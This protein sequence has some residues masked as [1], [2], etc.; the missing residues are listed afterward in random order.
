MYTLYTLHFSFTLPG[1]A[2]IRGLFMELYQCTLYTVHTLFTVNCTHTVHSVHCSHTL[3]GPA[4]LRGLVVE[5]D[6]CTLYTVHVVQ[7]TLCTWYT[8]HTVHTLYLAPLRSVASSWN[9]TTRFSFGLSDVSSLNQI[10]SN[11][12]CILKNVP[13]AYTCV[14]WDR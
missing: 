7:N 11:T 9:L 5:L 4:A 12:M 6:Q 8:L 1:P 3:P 14:L 13:S 10:Q 2:A